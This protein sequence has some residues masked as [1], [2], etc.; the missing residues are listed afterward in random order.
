MSAAEITSSTVLL[1]YQQRWIADTSKVKVAEKSRRIGLT[2]AEAADDA[3][4]AARANGMDTWYVGYNRDMTLEFIETVARWAKAFD[5]VAGEIEEAGEVLEDADREKGILAYKVKFAS[6]HKVVALSSRPSNLRGKQG[7]LVL[8]EAAFHDEPEEIMK[9]GLAY[10]IWGGEVRVI[11]THNGEE[12]PFNSL[13]QDVLAGRKAYSLHRITID[14]ALADGLYRRVCERSGDAWSAEAESAWRQWLMEQYGDA[15]Q[16]ELLVIPR[17]GGGSY[18]PRALIERRMQK[19]IPVVRLALP[20]GYAELQKEKRE[21]ETLEWCNLVLA[22]LLERLDPNS[23]SFIGEDFG[24]T[25][26]LTV[27]WPLQLRM[28][29]VRTTPF[30]VELRNVPFEQQRQI[31]FFIIDRLPRF[32]HGKFDGRGNG[33]YLAEVSMQ[34][35]GALRIEQVMIS[36]TWYRENMPRY[37]A[38][39][40]DGSIIAPADAEIL[41]DHGA[42]RMVNGVPCIP[43]GA[44]TRSTPGQQRHGDAAIAG[45]MAYAASR[46]D[47]GTFDYEAAPHT[48]RYRESAPDDDDEPRHRYGRRGRGRGGF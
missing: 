19:G 24:R 18:I 8:D 11:S 36:Q 5:L 25:G 3:L 7:R 23:L 17:S 38:A 10:L 32:L 1:P 31:T 26:D 47:L 16:E 27:L 12:N 28:D 43:D 37:K 15:A 33:Q 6:G 13:V 22:P 2:W 4:T 40:E 44:R 34:R 14:D 30:V 48:N 46:V 21:R 35:Y 41:N 9:A 29:L 42:L 39:Y 45:C 20:A